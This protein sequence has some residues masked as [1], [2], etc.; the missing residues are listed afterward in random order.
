MDQETGSSPEANK[1]GKNYFVLIGIIAV[2]VVV[3]AVGAFFFLNTSN[4]SSPA[5]TSNETQTTEETSDSVIDIS[6][7]CKGGENINAEFDNADRTVSLILPDGEEMT[8]KKTPSESGDRFANK[9]GSFVF[10]NKGNEATY[11]VD[12]ETV[13]SDCIAQ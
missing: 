11:D 4:N 13:Y 6:F 3:I 2:A 10:W 1:G 12:G 8:L 7:V 5:T 9:D